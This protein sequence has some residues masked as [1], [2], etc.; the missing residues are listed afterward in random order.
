MTA[1]KPT[2]SNY[3]CVSPKVWLQDAI[4]AARFRIEM[5]L[6][7]VHTLRCWCTVMS[8]LPHALTI[9][10][11][12]MHAVLACPAARLTRLKIGAALAA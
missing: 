9:C 1:H 3:R 8:A 10:L 6:T 2:F 5:V 7:R 12:R 11:S 4:A